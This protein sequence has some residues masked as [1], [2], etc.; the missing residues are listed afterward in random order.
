M[1]TAYPKL[2][3]HFW[4]LSPKMAIYWQSADC[5]WLP[6]KKWL[7]SNLGKNLD[8]SHRRQARKT[9][10]NFADHPLSVRK[11]CLSKNAQI[12]VSKF[13][14]FP[15]KSSKTWFDLADLAGTWFLVKKRPKIIFYHFDIASKKARKKKKFKTWSSAIFWRRINSDAFRKLFET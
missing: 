2:V 3:P 9:W 14:Y 8:A 1:K 11:V 5:T 13:L 12:H 6:I 4:H 7:C 10:L 15:G